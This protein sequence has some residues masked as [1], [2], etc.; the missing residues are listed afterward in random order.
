MDRI[1]KVNKLWHEIINLLPDVY[2]VN[3]EDRPYRFMINSGCGYILSTSEQEVEAIANLFDQLYDT[4]TC[5]TGYYDP[6]EDKRNGEE[7]VYTG[8]YW[9]GI[10]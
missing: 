5:H 4:G 6:N 7:D 8:L 10:D 9:V 1:N 3:D 2:D